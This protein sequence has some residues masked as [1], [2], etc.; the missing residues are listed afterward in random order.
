ML[1]ND[2]N[3][4][5]RLNSPQNLINKLKNSSRNDAMK[6]FTGNIRKEV[7]SEAGSIST[8]SGISVEKGDASLTR[9]TINPFEKPKE[10]PPPEPILDTILKDSES[11]IKLG[12]AHDKSLDLL[13]RSVDMLAQKL[14]DIKA[15]KLPSVVSAASKVVEGIRKERNEASK[16]KDREVHYHFYTPQQRKMEEFEIIDVNKEVIEAQSGA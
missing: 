12:L 7:P 5:K 11:Q 2:E 15:D 16:N 13:T 8:T 6:L 4:L 14:D 3:T 1:M 10:I 9:I